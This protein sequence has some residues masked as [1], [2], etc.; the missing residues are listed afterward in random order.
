M[1]QVAAYFGSGLDDFGITTSDWSGSDGNGAF[2]FRAVKLDTANQGNVVLA[3]AGNQ[4]YGILQNAPR[5]NE[6][7]QVRYIGLTKV[8]LGGTVATG[9]PL[10]PDANGNLVKWTT[11]SSKYIVGRAKQAGVSGDIITA[12][13]EATSEYFA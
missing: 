12:M 9:D 8:Q 11:G 6:T 3:V 7:C 10:T 13:I 5:A 4:I 1:T 2:Q